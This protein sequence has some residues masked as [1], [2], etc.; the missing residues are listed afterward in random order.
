MCDIERRRSRRFPLQQLAILR[1]WDSIALEL[2]GAAENASLNGVFVCMDQPLP[3]GSWV[4]IT[5]PMQASP[6]AN[7]VQLHGAGTV[8]R[9]EQKD[10]K[11]KLA[12]ACDLPLSNC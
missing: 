10:G 12:I 6:T 5:I 4:E 9:T 1:I 11:H 2:V 7:V 8:V 3:E